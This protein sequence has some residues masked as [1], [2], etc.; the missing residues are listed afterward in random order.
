MCSIPEKIVLKS[1]FVLILK[2]VHQKL[3]SRYDF[4][5]GN[6]FSS[7][8]LIIPIFAFPGIWLAA[9]CPG[10]VCELPRMKIAA[11]R[12]PHD[13]PKNYWYLLKFVA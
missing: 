12:A 8:I 6:C 5:I 1:V 13:L 11:S 10:R 3:S 9:P 2:S 4:E 7:S